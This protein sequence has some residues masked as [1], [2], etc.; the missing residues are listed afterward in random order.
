VRFTWGR[1]T[2]HKGEGEGSALLALVAGAGG[3]GFSRF[4]YHK[5]FL[6]LKYKHIALIFG[7][8]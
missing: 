3:L 5:A 7:D 2:H 6:G 4:L 1:S 8:N